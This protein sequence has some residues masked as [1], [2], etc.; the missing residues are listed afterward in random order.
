MSDA[1]PI[2]SIIAGIISVFALFSASKYKGQREEL[3]K[4]NKGRNEEVKREPIEKQV[5]R[6]KSEIKKTEA[7]I[8]NGQEVFSKLDKELKKISE[9]LVPIDV[10]IYPPTFAFDDSEKLKERRF[11]S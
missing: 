1:Y 2:I 11:S 10:G 4:Q 5:E 3:E 6:L 8:E 9:E 7:K